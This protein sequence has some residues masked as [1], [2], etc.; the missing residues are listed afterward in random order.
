MNFCQI[1]AKTIRVKVLL[2]TDINSWPSA[3]QRQRPAAA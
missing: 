3:V 1:E 2:Q